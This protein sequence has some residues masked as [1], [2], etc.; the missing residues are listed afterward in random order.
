MLPEIEGLRNLQKFSEGWRGVIYVGD[1]GGER[2]ALK[3]AKD[4]SRIKAINREA[5]I[6]ERL[7]GIEFF[8]YLLLRG[9]G[10]FAYRF[11]EGKP[12]GKVYGTLSLKERAKVIEDILRAAYRLD[13]MG[14]RR[15]E[16]SKIGKNVLIGKGNRV[17]IL[18]FDRGNFTDRPANLPQ[19]LQFLVREGILD[20][21]SAIELGRR[22]RE[23]REGVYR[24]L[25]GLI[26]GYP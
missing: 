5:D 14:I 12:F 13:G 19:F 1:Y 8:P 23:D 20:L 7:R 21:R 9:K 18:D 17:Y 26:R 25:I 11:I 4:E 3:V 6:L 10:F 2:V 24:K 15:N 16:F 22:Y